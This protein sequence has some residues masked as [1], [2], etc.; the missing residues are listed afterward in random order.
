MLLVTLLNRVM[1]TGSLA[2]VDP[3]GRRHQAGA[4]DRTPRLTLR[5]HD[6]KTARRLYLRPRLEIGEAFMDGRVTVE[7][8]TVYELLE[9][10]LQDLGPADGQPFARLR[11]AL[12]PLR[13]FI[14]QY[15]PG[16]LSRRRVSHHYDLSD[17]LF[18]LFLDEDWQY[19]CA[20]FPN[21]AVS[22]EEAQAAKKR[23]IAAKLL[24]QPGQ[25][26][27]DIGSG[28]GGLAIS[29]AKAAPVS[30]TGITLSHEQLEVSRRRA[31]E[32]GLSDRVTFEL[33]DYRTLDGRFDRIV[34][35]GMFEHVG[36]P[37]YAAFFNKIATLLNADG[38]ALVHSIGRME[39]PGVTNPWLRK[40]IFPGGYSPALSEVTPVA[41]RAALWITDIEILRLH[42][43]ETLRHWRRRFLENWN[44]AAAPYDDRF[45]RMW[46]FYLAACELSFRY[47]GQMVFQMQLAKRVDTVPITRDYLYEP[48]RQQRHGEMAA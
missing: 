9:L 37:H 8:G 38:I 34:S 25:R 36:V 45:C 20:Y 11:A 18:G 30:V 29:L 7:G 15:N 32:A 43:A 24:L 40:Y 17:E 21:S 35:V 41:E 14:E 3:A 44:R 47:A 12:I 2:V 26:I 6:R 13:R 48:R 28:W 22:L 4:Q 46:E 27:L 42:Y 19:S 31:A 16:A 39:G 23:H 33:M 1:K 5:V 10:L